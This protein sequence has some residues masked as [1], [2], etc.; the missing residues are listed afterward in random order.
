MQSQ[1]KKLVK[2][3]IFKMNIIKAYKLKFKSGFHIDSYGNQSYS[4]SDNFIHS[5]TL[6]SALLSVWALRYPE[7]I[8]QTLNSPP[9]LLSSAFPFYKNI[10]FL[11]IP[12]GRN[13]VKEN[14][15][16]EE[17]KEESIQRKELKKVQFIPA[18]LW[19]HLLSDSDYFL[20]FKKD[21]NENHF[22]YS[23]EEQY[24][25]MS[26]FLI[27]KNLFQKKEKESVGDE[28]E[29]FN[30]KNHTIWSTE[31]N[32]RVSINR[33]DNQSEDGQLFS[34][35]RAYLKQSGGLYFLACF[36][37]ENQQKEFEEILAILGDTGLG[38]DKNCGHGLFEV[39]KE[40]KSPVSLLYNKQLELWTVQTSDKSEDH[41][42]LSSL[43]SL[44]LFCPNE[45]EQKQMSWM[46]SEDKSKRANYEL[47]NRGGW[48]HNT[49][50][51]RKTLFMFMEGSQFIKPKDMNLKGKIFD[52][53]PDISQLDHKVFRDGRGF[54]IGF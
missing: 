12:K 24:N 49:S 37:G 30:E 10:F 26:E 13:L 41:Q 29:V 4:K 45:S 43:C 31:E 42:K 25:F 44:S 52:V 36:T 53:S 19:V 35:S 33:Q 16:T 28:Q 47:K 27:P 48:I 20:N 3:R 17:Q 6:S 34:F 50:L 8:E 32:I 23:I 11:P 39:C 15:F 22:L 14:G 38:G 21:K 5:D 7:N 2:K 46:E 18:D 9:Y 40:E 54:F 1:R 51:R